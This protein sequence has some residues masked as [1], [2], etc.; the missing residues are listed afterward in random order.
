MKRRA[1]ALATTP[2]VYV[3]TGESAIREGLFRM[4]RAWREGGGRAAGDRVVAVKPF[5]L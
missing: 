5:M 1:D 3:R 4:A 2:A